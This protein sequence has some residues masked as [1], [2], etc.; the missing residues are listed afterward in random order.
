MDIDLK[1]STWM[2]NGSIRSSLRSWKKRNSLRPRMKNDY[3][4]TLDLC[5]CRLQQSQF[6][7]DLAEL[8]PVRR[9]N[10]Y[11]RESVVL[12]DEA[13]HRKSSFHRNR[14]GLD[15]IDIHQGPQLVMK[16]FC[17]RE[18]PFHRSL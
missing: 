7:D 8:F 15:K 9:G 4:R 13:H 14:I 3:R 6:F 12:F 18:I 17:F 11:H 1:W 10:L 2:G 5:A 16:I